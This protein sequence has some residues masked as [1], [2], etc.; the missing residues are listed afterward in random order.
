MDNL[1]GKQGF[2]E[3]TRN[4]GAGIGS[5]PSLFPEVLAV[6][7]LPPACVATARNGIRVLSVGKIH[8]FN[9]GCACP[10]GSL[11]R[12]LFASLRPG[13]KDVVIV[14]TA[15]GVEHFG[16]GLDGLCDRILCV[17]DPSFES[18]TMAGRVQALAREAGLPSGL[19]LNRVTTETETEL[20]AALDTAGIIGR[21]PYSRALFL[22]TLKGRPL[23]SDLPEMDT[24]CD[25]LLGE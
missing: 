16:R 7:E 20:D 22:D 3:K 11:F 9:E 2:R 12:M 18:I 5:R 1:G 25:R 8:H 15:A 24:L 21:L 13:E 10:M 4:A 14:D 19:I 23:S 17:V 6:D